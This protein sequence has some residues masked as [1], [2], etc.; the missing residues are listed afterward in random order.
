MKTTQLNLVG[1]SLFVCTWLVVTAPAENRTEVRRGNPPS[2][3]DWIT[4]LDT[5]GDGLVSPDEF[6]GPSEHFGHLDTG[7]D[8]Y[9]DESEAPKGPP[10][11]RRARRGQASDDRRSEPENR[12]SYD[13]RERPESPPTGDAFISMQDEDGD[14]QVSREEFRGPIEHFDH[15]DRNEDGMISRDEAPD[16]PPRGRDHKGQGNR[17]RVKAVLS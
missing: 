6:D 10:P 1:C 11:G 7:G 3:A 12:V 2:P 8:G 17:E 16:G 14:G 5:D 9:I 4:R 15:F 13:S